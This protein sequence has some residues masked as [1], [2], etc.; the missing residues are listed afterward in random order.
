MD[1]KIEIDV[2]GKT[3]STTLG[4]YESLDGQNKSQY[5]IIGSNVIRSFK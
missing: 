3:N 4:I 1:S 2:C 5:Q